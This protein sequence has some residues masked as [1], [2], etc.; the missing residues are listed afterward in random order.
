MNYHLTLIGVIIMKRSRNNKCWWGHGEKRTRLHCWWECKLVQPLWKTVWRCLKKLNT[1]LLYD[2][3]ILLLVLYIYIHTHKH[4]YTH[5]YNGILFSYKKK[6]N[7]AIYS[8]VDGFR[9]YHTKG[10]KSGRES[11][12]PY[13]IT[14]MWNSKYDPNEII[15]ETKSET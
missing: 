10:N 13:N 7:N 6:W 12:I 9:A 11:Q 15:Y 5:P 1:V 3:E 14:Y 8:N 2:L 4:T